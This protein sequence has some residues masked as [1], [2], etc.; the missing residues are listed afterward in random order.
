MKLPHTVSGIVEHGSGDGRR[1]G[2]PT[3]NV[4]LSEKLSLSFG[5][6]AAWLTCNTGKHASVLHYG[7]RLVFGES[8]PLFEVH[9]L[10]TDL[11]LYGQEVSVELSH[12]VRSTRNFASLDELVAQMNLDKQTAKRLLNV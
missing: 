10:D 3:A 6:Y 11:D 4:R 1:L 2:F 7:P 9:V 5:V 8:H 12:F